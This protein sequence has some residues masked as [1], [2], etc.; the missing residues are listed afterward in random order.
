MGNPPAKTMEEFMHEDHPFTGEPE[1][2]EG[3]DACGEECGVEMR[4]GKYIKT[5]TR[6]YNMPGGAT[7][8]V[9]CVIEED[10]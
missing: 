7:E 9:K 5:I 6:T 1:G 2:N 10:C 3:Y 8:V 4:D